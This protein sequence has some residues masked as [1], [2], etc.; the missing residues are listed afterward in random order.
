MKFAY[1]SFLLLHFEYYCFIFLLWVHILVTRNAYLF[2]FNLLIL[3]LLSKLAKCS[4]LPETAAQLVLQLSCVSWYHWVNK[5]RGITEK[6]WSRGEE[7]RVG[8]LVPIVDMILLL[9]W[10]AL[11]AISYTVKVFHHFT[12]ERC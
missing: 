6:Q 3:S 11:I 7:L 1:G 5:K 10:G 9:F 2:N 12:D 4:H 8:H